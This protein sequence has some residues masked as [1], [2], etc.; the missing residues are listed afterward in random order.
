MMY[1]DKTRMHS[2]RMHTELLIDR[3]LASASQRR[4][5]HG[6][7]GVS[8][9]GG[10]S[11]PGGLW[12]RGVSLVLGGSPWSRGVSPLWGVSLVRGGLQAGR[13]IPVPRENLPCEPRITHTCK[14]ITLATTS[15]RPVM[16]TCS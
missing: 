16:M 11:G 13:L 4:I 8:G 14:N 15:L 1:V 12:S 9:S 10:V 6:P 7:G 3:M 2:S 5:C